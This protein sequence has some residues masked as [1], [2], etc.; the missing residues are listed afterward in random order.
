MATIESP[1]CGTE[2]STFRRKHQIVFVAVAILLLLAAT[3]KAQALWFDPTPS[4]SVLSSP[5]WQMALIFVEA[6]LAFWL[7]SGVNPQGAWLAGISVFTLFSAINLYLA[8][9]G[10]PSCGCL[11]RVTVHPLLILV[12]DI[13]VVGLLLCC[14]PLA[15]QSSTQYSSI[16]FANGRSKG[17]LCLGLGSLCFGILVL[18]SSVDSPIASAIAALRGESATLEPE[19]TH[20]GS[21]FAGEVRFFSVKV[22]NHSGSP[23]RII[24]GTADCECDTTRDLPLIIPPGESRPIPVA[25]RLASKSGAFDIPFYLLTDSEFQPRVLGRITGTVVLQA[26][27]VETEKLRA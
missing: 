26:G 21:A 25:V 10:V 2:R 8:T 1:S 5:R 4:L 17:W 3:L 9:S 16:L 27:T 12:M 14:R 11:G 20:V 23:L 22:R 24:G 6:N 7:L 19:C 18:L 13:A 15:P